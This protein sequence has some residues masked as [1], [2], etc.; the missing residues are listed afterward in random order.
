MASYGAI[1]ASLFSTFT[2]NVPFLLSVYE[3]YLTA[4]ALKKGVWLNFIYRI[5]FRK[6]KRW[7]LI[8][9]MSERQKAWLESEKNVQIVEFNQDWDLLAKRTK[10]M[11]QELEILSTRI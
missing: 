10:E 3:G 4:K 2:K 7:Q 9:K 6:A 11:F 1:A 8:A 5:I